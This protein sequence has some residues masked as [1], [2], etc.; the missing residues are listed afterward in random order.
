MLF[1]AVVFLVC[2]FQGQYSAL[3]VCYLL[4][5]LQKHTTH[6]WKGAPLFPSLLPPTEKGKFS[7]KVF[8]PKKEGKKM[9]EGEN[10]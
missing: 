10:N 5:V 9:R 3:V 2:C 6:V 1:R 4:A 7:S 8:P